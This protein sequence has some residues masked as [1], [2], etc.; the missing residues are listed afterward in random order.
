M[1]DDKKVE[2]LLAGVEKPGEILVKFKSFLQENPDFLKSIRDFE[3]SKKG[4]FAG[5]VPEAE[6]THEQTQAH[7]DFVALM[8]GQL[9]KF[10][11]HCNMTETA[12]FS[13][14]KSASEKDPQIATFLC[15]VLQKTDFLQ[16]ASK[17]AKKN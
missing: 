15:A 11:E 4:L 12:V 17:L 16:W 13:L 6:H 1:A 7:R 9:T 10:C 8:D 2:E 14:A 3:D 5:F